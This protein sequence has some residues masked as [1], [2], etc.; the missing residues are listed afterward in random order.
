M[1]RVVTMKLLSIGVGYTL[2][3]A[4]WS[5]CLPEASAN[6]RAVETMHSGA[7]FQPKQY[8]IRYATGFDIAYHEGFKVI[9]VFEPGKPGMIRKTLN[10]LVLVPRGSHPPAGVEGTIVE[11]PLSRVV[12]RS[13]SHVPFFS[14]LGLTDRIVAVAQGQYVNDPQVRTLIMQKH[15]A[16]VGTGS[17]MTARLNVEKLFTLHPDLVLSWWTNNPSFAG[18]IKAKEAGFP[19]VLTT[20]YEEHTVL[21]RT[22]W[23][24]FVAA[25]FDAEHEAERV[26]EDIEKRY[27]SLTAKTK[28]V[29]K[30]P[31][32]MYG[33]SFGGSWYIAGGR[34]LFSNLVEDAGGRYVWREDPNTGSRAV[35]V[36]SAIIKGKEADYW[37]TQ[38]IDHFSLAS[39]LAEDDRYKLFKAFHYGDVYSNNG[40]IGPGGG[41]DY[42]QGT[43]ARP[44]LLLA[45]MIAILHPE[46]LPDH[47]LI[48]H[49]QLPRHIQH[50]AGQK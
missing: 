50:Q 21:G 20:D 49:V 45:D 9:R 6:A 19:V 23:V 13:S 8:H 7:W 34:G 17:G 3:L 18:H 46:L 16:E 10:T 11:T 43:I 31:T 44:D 29:R 42:Y 24:K 39:I 30:R 41:N 25:F 1:S 37:F 27:L 15:I 28:G 14:M 47:K 12:L 35:T 4:A 2:L 36:E 40:K 26:F 48:W 5:S 38:N 22:E 32:V 33:N